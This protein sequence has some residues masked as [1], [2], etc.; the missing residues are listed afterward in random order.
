MTELYA[1]VARVD[2]DAICHNVR[3]ARELSPGLKVLVAVK[4]QAY[5]HG[6]VAVAR[7]LADERLADW[8]GVATTP[9]GI[10]LREAGIELPILRLSH[11]FAEELPSALAADLALPVVDEHTIDAV[12]RAAERLGRDR[13]PVHLAIDTG[14]GRIGCRPEAATALAARVVARGL[15]LQ[16]LYT[17]LPISDTQAG[18]EF[19]RDQL[20]L[21]AA[22]VA[23]VQRE[24]T[25]A[26]LDP[27]PLVHAANSGAVLGHRAE[28]CTMVRPGI[29]VYGYY[30]DLAGT[31]RPVELRPALTWTSRVSFV[32][33]VPAGR[34]VGYGR[35]WTAPVESWLATVPI[36][37]GDGYSRL[38]SNRGRM[39]VGGRSYPV[40]GR[41]CMDQT[42]L[43]LGPALPGQPAP[44]QAGDEV[45]V[46]G[47]QGE[48]TISTD[49]LAELMGTI[50]YE[51]TCLVGSRV[52]RVHSS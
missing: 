35:T 22:T 31:P 1:T 51:V 8:L 4:A 17:H 29:M 11:A 23:A 32:K 49:E 5:G 7:R 27:V 6:A 50:N 38:N 45:V 10:E 40:A 42:M 26:G 16:G 12:A 39:L 24:R 34:T 36:G 20:E 28:V 2:L 41:V 3:A 43:D 14:M 33:R 21:F 9:E 15:D 18:D 52:P 47:T 19:T 13:Y 46:L 30:P 25:A 48:Q 44:V 37:Y